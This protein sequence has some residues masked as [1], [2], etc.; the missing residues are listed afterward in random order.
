MSH[1]RVIICRVDDSSDDQMTELAS[2][3]LVEPKISEMEADR[4]LDE[5]EATT[6]RVG[7]QV[8]RELFRAQWEEVDQ[9]LVEQY[10]QDF[11]P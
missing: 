1:L 2:F 3:D 8:L 9:I 6:A 11:S 10:R 4:A 5:M 7:H